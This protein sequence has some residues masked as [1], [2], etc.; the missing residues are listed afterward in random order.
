MAAA[1]AEFRLVHASAEATG[2]TDASFD[3]V[4]CDHGAMTFA[5]PRRTIPKAAPAAHRRRAFAMRTPIL[6]MA[7]EPE[8]DHPFDRL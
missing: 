4:F 7:S 3:I 2:L 1:G 5:D 8:H 6:D